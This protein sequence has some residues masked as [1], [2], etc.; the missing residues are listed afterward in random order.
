[1]QLVVP[2]LSISA[3]RKGGFGRR[4][5]DEARTRRCTRTFGQP[6]VPYQSRRPFR[7][8]VS[9]FLVHCPRINKLKRNKPSVNVLSP[10]THYYFATFSSK[11]VIVARSQPYAKRH[12][13]EF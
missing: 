11:K 3:V 9:S 10:A 13:V 6:R 4:Q 8:T 5:V 2:T 12:N 7:R 1:M